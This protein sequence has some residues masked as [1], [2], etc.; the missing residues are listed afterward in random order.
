MEILG[1]LLLLIKVIIG[2]FSIWRY[3]SL[4]AYNKAFDETPEY[5]LS[6]FVGTTVSITESIKTYKE[7]FSGIFFLA[8][9]SLFG[10]VFKAIISVAITFYFTKFLKNPPKGIEWIKSKFI[11]KKIKK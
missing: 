5:F 2:V 7:D 8:L 11:N 4:D 1:K 3:K 10:V 6:L 9:T